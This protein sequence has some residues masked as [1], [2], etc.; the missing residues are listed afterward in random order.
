MMSLSVNAGSTE[1]MLVTGC[2]V[3]EVVNLAHERVRAHN[4]G[5]GGS[6]T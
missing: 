6:G 1:T 4:S 2:G 3:V 5:V